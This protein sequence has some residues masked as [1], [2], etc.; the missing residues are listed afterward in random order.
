LR[1][2]SG[3]FVVASLAF[4]LHAQQ[5]FTGKIDVSVVNVDVTVTSHGKPVHGLARDDFEVLEDGVL[6]QITNFYALEPGTPARALGGVEG[7]A[8]PDTERFRRHVLL[9]IDNTHLSRFNRDRALASLESFINDRFK[10]GDYD[11]S[12]ASV[13]YGGP[14]LLLQQTS[15]KTA[16]HTALN[17]IRR[18][19]ARG[20]EVK[21]LRGNI[22]AITPTDQPA[23]AGGVLDEIDIREG[24]YDALPVQRAIVDGVRA[25]AGTP[26]KKVLLLI[27]GSVGLYTTGRPD[28]DRAMAVLRDTITR[29]VNAANVN[30]YILDPNGP[31]SSGYMYWLARETG[32]RF[33]P[34][35]FPETSM[36]QFDIAS[37]NFYSLG[38]HSP[39]PDD[40]RYHRIVVRV[41]N[42]RSCS[43]NYRDGYATL[44]RELEI[45]RALRTPLSASLQ[46]ASLPLAATTGSIVSD[47]DGAVVPIEVRVPLKELQFVPG[48]KGDW[49]AFVDIYVSVFDEDGRNLTLK[50][51]TT[52][53]TA[54]KADNDGDLIHN[55]TV[56]FGIGKPHTIVVAVRDQTNEALGVWQQ[57]VG[58]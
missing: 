1:L 30:L 4:P 11:W 55:A 9:L 39:H 45:A 5:T 23:P 18:A 3:L 2:C 32:G 15:D 37:S 48:D 28:V 10:G 19:A 6:Q 58:F 53:A 46:G 29:E 50:R 8:P 54:P 57:T 49:K 36:Q 24:L 43:I 38:Y 35:S 44:P 7:S 42:C 26:G 17:A 56:A 51:F 52:T 12:I 20:F 16:I 31:E 22:V 25:F 40:Q 33:M 34:S 41:K 21:D 27:T 47:R 13:G 14:R